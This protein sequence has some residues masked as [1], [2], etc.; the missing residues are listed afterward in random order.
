[1]CEA[2]AAR[3]ARLRRYHAAQQRSLATRRRSQLVTPAP[4]TWWPPAPGGRA[5]DPAVSHAASSA[6]PDD[7]SATDL[8]LHR[9][10]GARCLP[11]GRAGGIKIAADEFALA[12][13]VRLDV[14][15][16]SG[17]ECVRT[18]TGQVAASIGSK[19]RPHALQ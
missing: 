2:G 17:D 9:R 11:D 8:G 15:Q 6:S 18:A 13:P 16:R 4:R 12:R 1:C 14:L 5:P 19:T 3:F 7:G 10:I